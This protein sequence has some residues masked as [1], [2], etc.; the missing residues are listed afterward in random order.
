MSAPRH[1]GSEGGTSGLDN[2]KYLLRPADGLASLL[3][4]VHHIVNRPI[5]PTI[6]TYTVKCERFDPENCCEPCQ[7]EQRTGELT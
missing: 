4:S 7:S 3:A 1:T 6:N 5:D 2:S